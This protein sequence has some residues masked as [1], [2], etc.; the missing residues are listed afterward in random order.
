MG[1]NLIDH[2][3]LERNRA[4][5]RL[6]HADQQTDHRGLAAARWTDDGQEFTIMDIEV[7]SMK[8]SEVTK[9]LGHA[10]ELEDDR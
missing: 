10:V 4:L 3:T 2:L 8:R 6:I 1:W 9:P 5:A 7:D